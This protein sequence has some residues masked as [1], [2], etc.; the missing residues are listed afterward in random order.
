[1]LMRGSLGICYPDNSLIIFLSLSFSVIS[2]Q[3]LRKMVPLNRVHC[4]QQRQ[5]AVDIVVT[6]C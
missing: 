6:Y 5:D 2:T 4:L 3:W 1:M